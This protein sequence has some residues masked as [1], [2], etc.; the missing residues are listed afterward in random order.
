M[1][2][3]ASHATIEVTD[4][5]IDLKNGSRCQSLRHNLPELT[6]GQVLMRIDEFALTA[7]NV[8]YCLLGELFGYWRFFP[9]PEG[10]G[11]VPVWGFATVQA[12]QHPEVEAGS[13]YYGYWPMSSHLII[14]A[15]QV[16]ARGLR[17][18]APHRQPLPMIYNRYSLAGAANPTCDAIRSLVEPL[19]T[20]AFL[21][22]DQLAENQ[23]Y[24][25]SDVLIT[26]ASSKTA[27][28]LAFV[29]AQQ[30]APG[31]RVVGLTSPGNR[32]FV[33]GLG[34]YD[35]VT[36]YAEVAMLAA[37]TPV[38]VVD[39]AGSASL[40]A[41][42]HQHFGDNLKCD[43]V[44]GLSHAALDKGHNK[45]PGAKPQQFF[46]PAQAE[47]R[48]KDWGAAGFAGRVGSA[49]EPFAAKA[50]TTLQVSRQSG[51]EAVMAIWRDLVAGSADPAVGLIGQL[52]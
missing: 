51:P 42:L 40:R 17:D 16:T 27:F 9:A 44:V 34:C 37:N 46:A 28:A 8:T 33:A 29:M 26:S 49:W 21:V 43:L 18:N 35:A 52:T 47:Q 5:V 25:A 14:D 30:R 12:S 3:L 36:T 39:F 4:I 19:F 6:A 45:L 13:R 10:W 48:M 11:R 41:E 38:A 31:V 7:N 22:N 1:N 50:A 20:T 2:T 24:G 32:D 23:F 15:D